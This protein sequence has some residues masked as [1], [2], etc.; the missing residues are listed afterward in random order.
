MNELFLSDEELDELE[1]FLV[2]RIIEDDDTY[3]KDEG[4]LDISELDGLLTAIVSGPVDIAASEWLLAVWGDFEPSWMD[5]DDLEHMVSL[6]IRHKNGIAAV[7]AEY[8]SHFEPLFLEQ[9][10][11]G[12]HYTVVD[13]WCHGYVRGIELCIDQWNINDSDMNKLL[14][15]IM[16]FAGEETWQ[17]LDE[18]S[19]SEIDYM[20]QAIVPA[21]L[22][23][24]TWWAT[25][26]LPAANELGKTSRT[27]S[28]RVDRNDPC[29]CGSGKKY[30]KC[31]LH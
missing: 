10:V 18:L 16:A 23:I 30:R 17:T 26:G 22:E 6:M 11:E 2:G 21:V 7:L 29:P 19:D 27:T 14:Q 13:E 1:E 3:G 25:R 4:V 9:E 15:P 28:L 12:K 8:P 24:H 31:C 5:H 20:Q